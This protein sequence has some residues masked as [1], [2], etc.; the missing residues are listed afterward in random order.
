MSDKDIWESKMRNKAVAES[1]NTKPAPKGGLTKLIKRGKIRFETVED[2]IKKLQDRVTE[3][4]AELAKIKKYLN[5]ENKR[6]RKQ[7]NIRDNNG[8]ND[9]PQTDNQ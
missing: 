4:E 8:N 6:N 9:R 2:P 7:S 3:L 5:Y 1:F